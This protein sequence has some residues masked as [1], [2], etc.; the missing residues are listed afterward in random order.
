MQALPCIILIA[1]GFIDISSKFLININHQLAIKTPNKR[2]EKSRLAKTVISSNQEDVFRVWL[3]RDFV[4]PLIDS[5][6]V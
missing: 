5:I 4:M 1:L 2:G 6:I 3:K